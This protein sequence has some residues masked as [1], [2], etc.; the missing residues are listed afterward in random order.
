[1]LDWEEGGLPR[2]ANPFESC[3]RVVRRMKPASVKNLE[4][5]W[6]REK[7]RVSSQSP[8]E[9]A[10][11]GTN[12]AW[13]MDRTGEHGSAL[14]FA[15]NSEEISPCSPRQPDRCSIRLAKGFLLIESSRRVVSA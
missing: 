11:H 13:K 15:R 14:D 5:I 9:I 2:P 6:P 10:V 3:C 12:Q 4:T 7:W 8:A 1:M